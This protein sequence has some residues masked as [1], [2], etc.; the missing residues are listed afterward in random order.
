MSKLLA[1]IIAAVFA[2]VSFGAIAAADDKKAGDK[3]EV[4]APAAKKD[5]A[6]AAKKEAK[7]E[8]KEGEKK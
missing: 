3:K 7:K 5:A 1:L 4:A 2:S 6:P 8:K